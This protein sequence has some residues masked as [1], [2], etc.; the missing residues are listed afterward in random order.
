MTADKRC[1]S[2]FWFDRADA[3]DEALE[4]GSEQ[5]DIGGNGTEPGPVQEELHTV[6]FLRLDR[7]RSRR[8]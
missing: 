6:W 4:E 5:L 2:F 7:I 3:D 1:A 8:R